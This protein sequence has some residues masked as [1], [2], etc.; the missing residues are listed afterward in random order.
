MFIKLSE[1]IARAN[2]MLRLVTI[3]DLSS[4]VLR[5]GGGGGGVWGGSP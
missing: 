3:Y 5:G 2:P 4:I 1:L